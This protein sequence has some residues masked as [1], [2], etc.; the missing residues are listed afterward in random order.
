MGI[1]GCR[2]AF[3]LLL[4]MSAH[5]FLN[6]GA[7]ANANN[8]ILKGVTAAKSTGTL[9]YAAEK[10]SEQDELAVSLPSF[11]IYINDQR[12]DVYNA[13]YPFLMYNDIT[14]LPMTWNNAKALGLRTTWDQGTGF[15]IN[16]EKQFIAQTVEQDFNSSG[17]ELTY[18]AK[19][20]KFNVSIEDA[21]Y[22]SSKEK[23]PVLVFRDVTY[24]PLT[25]DVAVEK[26]GISIKMEGTAELRLSKS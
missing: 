4:V 25:W 23:Y 3:A 14:Y 1:N 15:H 16:N 18:V 24:I 17:N 6:H 10:K 8:E 7:N 13:Q 21:L 26:L 22:D 9:V 5:L 2:S 20:P 11:K 12:V 19:V